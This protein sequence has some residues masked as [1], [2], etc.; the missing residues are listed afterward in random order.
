MFT[1]ETNRLVLDR[2][3]LDAAGTYQVV[4]SNAYGVDKQILNITVAPRRVRQRGQPNIHLQQDQYE[5]SPGQTIDIIP[6]IA[7]RTKQKNKLLY[8]NLFR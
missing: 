8:K 6:T 1:V 5:V 4:V 2:A 7:V 3:T